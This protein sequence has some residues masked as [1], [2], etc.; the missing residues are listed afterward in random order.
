MT[1]PGPSPRE[2]SWQPYK[3]VV[4]LDLKPSVT[5]YVLPIYTCKVGD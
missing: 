2:Q 5:M 4:R 1:S 3:D